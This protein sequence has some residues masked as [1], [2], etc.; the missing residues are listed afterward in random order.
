MTASTPHPGFKEK[1]QYRRK[2]HISEV[3]YA[4]GNCTFKNFIRDI[5]AYGIFIIT[6]ESFSVG[7]EL[8]LAIPLPNNKKNL[9]IDGIIARVSPQGIGVKFKTLLPNRVIDIFGI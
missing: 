3:Q 2:L 9:E 6:D 1:R 4:I 7:Q 8:S 5:S